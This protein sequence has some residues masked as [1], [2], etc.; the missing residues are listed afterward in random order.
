MRNRIVSID[1]TRKSNQT[2]KEVCD[3]VL[4]SLRK[5]KYFLMKNC[6]R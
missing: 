5:K 4:M 3:N 2:K 1:D 6:R